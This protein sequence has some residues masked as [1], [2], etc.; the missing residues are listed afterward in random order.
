SVAERRRTRSSLPP[1]LR[2]RNAWPRIPAPTPRPR[3]AAMAST[4]LASSRRDGAA[5]ASTAAMAP[6]PS[7]TAARAA[8]PRRDEGF[9][10]RRITR[11]V[12]SRTTRPPVLESR[13]GVDRARD[14]RRSVHR[15]SDGGDRWQRLLDRHGC[16]RRGPA[17]DRRDAAG[18]DAGGPCGLHRD[19]RREHPAQE[20]TAG[21][22][23]PHLGGWRD[24]E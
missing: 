19:G 20:A 17:G 8:G 13:R 21:L 10:A 1:S 14:V 22:L 18:G 2:S 4:A 7:I 15:S 24:E 12:C 16:R 9:G 11:M 6:T 5:M 3:A 23:L